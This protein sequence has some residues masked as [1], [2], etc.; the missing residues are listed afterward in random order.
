M[1]K[2]CFAHY[3]DFFSF[4]Y[5]YISNLL[6]TWWKCIDVI[7]QSWV[8]HSGQIFVRVGLVFKSQGWMS[9]PTLAQIM[10]NDIIIYILIGTHGE[11]CGDIKKTLRPVIL[12][13]ISYLWVYFALPK[14][15]QPPDVDATH[16][17]LLPPEMESRHM[18]CTSLWVASVGLTH[19]GLVTPY[20]DLELVQH[21]LR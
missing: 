1:V 7:I 21:W 4:W 5:L 10:F 2:K 13:H 8:R 14:G 17:S 3:H 12:L 15:S 9:H 11:L 20:N 18:V 19:C 16:C 6:L